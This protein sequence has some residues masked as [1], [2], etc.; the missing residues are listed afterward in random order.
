MGSRVLRIE[1][2]SVKGYKPELIKIIF[3]HIYP[4]HIKVEGPNIP[5]MKKRENLL[6]LFTAMSRNLFGIRVAKADIASIK[7]FSSSKRSPILV[8]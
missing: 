1:R 5:R 4:R 7:R 3:I 2:D 8:E 6:S